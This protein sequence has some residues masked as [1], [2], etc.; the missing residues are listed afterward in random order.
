MRQNWSSIA[1]FG[2]SNPVEIFTQVTAEY[3][4]A[5]EEPLVPL[6]IIECKLRPGQIDWHLLCNLGKEMNMD[7]NENPHLG[8]T[9]HID[10]NALYSREA[11]EAELEGIIEIETFLLRVQPRKRFKR[12]YWGQ[13]LIDGMNTSGLIGDV[14]PHRID[15]SFMQVKSRKCGKQPSSGLGRL[16][17]KDYRNLR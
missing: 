1:A 14:E 9:F 4:R 15:E 16:H 12:A 6:P 3:P 13:D 5:V 8:P 10:P 7:K 11:L 2:S 17:P